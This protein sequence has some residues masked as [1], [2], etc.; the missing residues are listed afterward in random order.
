MNTNG[1]PVVYYLDGNNLSYHYII[2]GFTISNLIPEVISVSIGY[3]GST[4]RTRDYTYGFSN[5]YAFMKNELIPYV[6]SKYN[7][8]KSNRTLFGHSFGG[9]CGL[10]TLFQNVNHETF[11][12][13]NII[14]SSPSIWW[15]DGQ[16]TY[17]CEQ[18]LYN[19]T[20]SLPVNFY[21]TMGSAEP[22]P[23]I[24]GFNRMSTTL[25]SRNYQYFNFKNVLNEGQSHGS[26]SEVSFRNGILWILNQPLPTSLKLTQNT[27]EKTMVYP[28]PAYNNLTIDTKSQLLGIFKVE[29]IN[30]SGQTVVKTSSDK[31][32]FNINTS[33]FPRGV[34]ILKLTDEKKQLLQ[35][36]IF[37]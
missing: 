30:L 27:L 11:P 22:D 18:A 4:Q 13:Q 25:I 19:S 37:Q 15:P 6:D 16:Y 31:Q 3:P 12:F 32:I 24:P 20:K 8:N 26:N 9:L 10:L 35:K 17:N 2:R 36:V 7:T 14:S 34:Y 1:Y 29:L 5:F 23:M 28:N 33:S 21:M